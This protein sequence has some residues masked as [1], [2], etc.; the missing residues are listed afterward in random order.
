MLLCSIAAVYLAQGKHDDA[1]ATW[2]A[3][4]EVWVK[5]L[6]L[7]H[8]DTAKTRENIANVYD[9]QGK[10]TEALELYM[11]VLAVKEKVLGLEHLE[12]AKTKVTLV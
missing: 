5:V 9:Q 3:V 12:P 10:H 7:E 2:Q 11:Q 1:L 8:L 6:G 4:L